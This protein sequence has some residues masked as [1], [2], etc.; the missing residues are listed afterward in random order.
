MIDD[1]FTQKN[2]RAAAIASLRY[3]Y[4]TRRLRIALRVDADF[5]YQGQVVSTRGLTHKYYEYASVPEEVFRCAP[6]GGA[7]PTYLKQFV[8]GRFALSEISEEVFT[9]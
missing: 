3:D 6:K 8:H 1:A 2:P 9:S 5:I 4:A 7:L